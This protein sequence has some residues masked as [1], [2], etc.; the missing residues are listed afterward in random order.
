MTDSGSSTSAA[1]LWV[2]LR[3]AKL[4]QWTLAYLA[5]VWL[6]L[7]VL[8]FLNDRFGW[9]PA[10]LRVATVVAGA[11][12][13]PMWV[14]AWFHGERG[15]QR[16]TGFEGVALALALAATIGAGWWAAQSRAFPVSR[17]S[18]APR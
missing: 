13:L 17:S 4:V 1:S 7:Q 18:R 16:V 9:D 8:E 5:S 10:L 15:A 12:V 14:L 3:A 6:L 2:R 11:A